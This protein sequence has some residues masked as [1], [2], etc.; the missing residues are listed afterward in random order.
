M[1]SGATMLPVAM[2]DVPAVLERVPRQRV[3]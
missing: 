3:P 2:F 1:I